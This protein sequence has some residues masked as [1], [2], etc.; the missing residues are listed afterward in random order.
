MSTAHALSVKLH[1][2]DE[3]TNGQTDEETRSSYRGTNR[4][5]S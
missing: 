2:T 5:A 4:D 3:R 1:L